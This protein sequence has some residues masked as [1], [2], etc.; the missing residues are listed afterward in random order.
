MIKNLFG[1]IF[2]DR[3]YISQ[4]LFQ[5]LLEQGVFIVTRV[6]K[7]MKNK[8]RSMLDK[9]LLLK[10]S[11]IESIFSKI[12]LLSKFEH[13]RHRSVTNAFVH[14]VAALINYQMSDNKPSITSLL[15]V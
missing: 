4:K 13:S 11:L 8:L 12:K 5:Q 7:N 3:D 14:M 10:R 9:I 6:K 15:I 2:G 1:K